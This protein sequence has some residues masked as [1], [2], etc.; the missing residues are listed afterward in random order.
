MYQYS[1]LALLSMAHGQAATSASFCAWFDATYNFPK[2][3]NNNALGDSNDA[4]IAYVSDG[5]SNCGK[6]GSGTPF[7]KTTHN[8]QA[9]GIADLNGNL[10]EVGLGMTAIAAAKTITGITQASPPV[11]TIIG[12]G[13]TTGDP[14]MITSVGGMTQVNNL[15]FTVT[16]IDADTFSLDGVDATLYTAYTS[17]GSSTKGTFYAAKEATRMADFT[18]G[19]TLATDNWG[20]TGVAA[21]MDAIDMPIGG[22]LPQRLGN[23]ANQV[24]SEAIS[25]AGYVKTG[26]GLPQ[27]VDGF[28]PGGTNLFG[29]DYYYQYIR[30]ELFPI[31]GGHWYYGSPAGIF[32]R[33]WGG[34]RVDAYD[35]FG[36]RCSA[37]GD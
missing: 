27:N 19:D 6:T 20:A 21:M 3:C 12:H 5:Y 1:A 29:T 26:L 8:G 22:S 15:I 25:G 28:S 14:V 18:S 24:F 31:L 36:F 11:V 23:A 35:S 30:N 10:W 32:A 37:Y 9:N 16:V 34:G 17:G 2:G 13:Y 4:T 33:N 7:A